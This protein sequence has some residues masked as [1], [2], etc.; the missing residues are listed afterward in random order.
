[1]GTLHNGSQ[2]PLMQST[3]VIP[4]FV[5]SLRPKRKRKN[6]LLKGNRAVEKNRS[7]TKNIFKLLHSL[8]VLQYLS[9]SFLEG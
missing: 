7:N 1:M 5:D 3:Y 8:N 4:K 2:S 6:K 9:N